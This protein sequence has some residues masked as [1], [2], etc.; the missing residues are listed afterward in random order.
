MNVE[1]MKEHEKSEGWGASVCS[2][3][4]RFPSWTEFYRH[5]GDHYRV[6][7]IVAQE[8]I[9]LLT[10][11]VD[12]GDA[13]VLRETAAILRRRFPGGYGRLGDDLTEI[14]AALVGVDSD[15]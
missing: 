13:A 3:G 8:V 7:L 4:E 11:R 1:G 12:S 14:A 5:R 10:Y 15:A 6:Q 9:D 2:C